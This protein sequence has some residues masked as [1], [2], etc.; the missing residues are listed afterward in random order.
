MSLSK[1]KISAPIVTHATLGG[2]SQFDYTFENGNLLLRFGRMSYFL[3]VK[4]ELIEV[5]KERVEKM[6]KTNI[7]IYK[8]TTSLY[9]QPK[10]QECPNNRI[11]VY[12]ACL[13]IN[14]KLKF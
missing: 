6:K 10:W 2:R 3:V 11:A 13:L 12:V 7:E 14:N 4:N 9:N 5:V 1:D 8:T